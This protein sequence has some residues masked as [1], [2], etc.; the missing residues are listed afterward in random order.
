M[1]QDLITLVTDTMNHFL[2]SPLNILNIKVTKEYTYI[3]GKKY[4]AIF[5]IHES[6][7]RLRICSCK[8][9]DWSEPYFLQQEI[10][11]TDPYHLVTSTL[12]KVT[13]SEDNID[14]CSQ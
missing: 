2:K 4:S 1:N 3:N 9:D 7:I 5:Y 14:N 12:N 10:K 6:P 13:E 8:M 11:N